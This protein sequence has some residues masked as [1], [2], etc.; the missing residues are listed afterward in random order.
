[1][2][3]LNRYI[4]LEFLRTSLAI[5]AGILVLYLTVAFLKEADDFIRHKASMSQIVR[6]FL[7]SLPGMA[8]QA[9]PFAALIGT[10]LSLGNLS[11]HNEITAMSAGGVSI[12]RIVLPVML[13]GVLLSAIGF[14]NNEMIMP[15]YAARAAHIRNVEVEGKPERVIFQQRRLWLRGPDNSI[16][17]IDLITPDRNEMIGVNIFKLSSDFSIRERI[18]AGRL[19]WQDGAW[20][21]RESRK[22]VPSDRAVTI[23]SADGEV[24]NVVDRPEDTGMI[25][26]GSKEM[27][28]IELYEY[29]NR[30]KSIGYKVGRHEV[31]LHGK[32]AIPFSCLLMVMIALPLSMQRVRSGGAARSIALAVM[33]AAVYWA[34][35]SGGRALG[36]SGTVEPVYAAW[37]GNAVFGV[38]AIALILRMQRRV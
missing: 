22:Y 19:V 32:I 25:A 31:D 30:L 29:V 17:N 23:R 12:F 2:K 34:L 13:G 6:Y 37:L 1:M 24:Y 26:K 5:L 15:K 18:T 10:L 28:F 14:A 7:F 27:S 3:L 4:F 21:L 38:L 8:G 33:V 16:A 20:K 11:R 35:M 9:L 36:L